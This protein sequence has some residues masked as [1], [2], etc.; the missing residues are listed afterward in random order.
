V[1]KF[2]IKFEISRIWHCSEKC[3]LPDLVAKFQILFS[4]YFSKNVT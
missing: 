3:S 4:N 1:T 2:G